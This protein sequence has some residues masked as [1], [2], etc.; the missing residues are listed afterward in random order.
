MN[1]RDLTLNSTTEQEGIDKLKFAIEGSGSAGLLVQS[2]CVGILQQPNFVLT[3]DLTTK[4]PPIND[5]LKTAQDNADNYLNNIQPKMIR[6]INDVGG[7]S[8]QFEAFVNPIFQLV[9]QWK[10][11]NDDAKIQAL[12]LFE[13]LQNEIEV[14]KRSVIVVEGDLTKFLSSLNTDVS[15][16][17]SAFNRASIVIG[18]NSG[19]IAEFSKNIADLDKQIGGA[20][21][22]VALSALSLIGG[23]FV[24]YIGGIISA[25]IAGAGTPLIAVGVGLTIAGTGSLIASSHGVS[26]F[27]QS[28]GDLI[29]QQLQFEK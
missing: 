5:F 3:P 15:N 24:I 11:G 7:Y 2:Y 29:T 21:A 17:S 19:A 8:G 22:G 20:A 25:L 10:N 27:S 13:S 18:G 14:K 28:Q 16:F 1:I 9:D 23:I 26:R 6:T 12:Q 4:L